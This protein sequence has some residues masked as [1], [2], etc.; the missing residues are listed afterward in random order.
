MESKFKF[1]CTGELPYLLTHGALCMR[2][3]HPELLTWYYNSYPV[4]ISLLSICTGTISYPSIPLKAAQNRWLRQTTKI[5]F[6]FS[7]NDVFEHNHASSPVSKKVIGKRSVRRTSSDS[8]GSRLR[9]ISFEIG[10]GR[11][12]SDEF[13][14][15]GLSQVCSLLCLLMSPCTCCRSFSSGFLLILNQTRSFCFKL[16]SW[17]KILGKILA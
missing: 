5:L 14:S 10:N 4:I 15:E 11:R 12:H 1:S 7:K 17:T 8:V 16:Q 9:K 6:L 13:A 3:W 2:L